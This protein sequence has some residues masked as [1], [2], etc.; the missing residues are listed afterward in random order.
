ML[1]AKIFCL[2]LGLL[3]GDEDLRFVLFAGGCIILGGHEGVIDIFSEEDL[4]GVCQIDD[5]IVIGSS[6]GV[7]IGGGI[8]GVSSG[9]NIG[10]L[11]CSHIIDG[12]Q[13]SG[14]I[15]IIDNRLGFEHSGLIITLFIQ[16]II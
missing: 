14:S 10:G 13:V 11:I 5:R 9:D 15:I 16:I 7:R 12:L 3:V 8:S 2:K 1:G 4:T 6:Q